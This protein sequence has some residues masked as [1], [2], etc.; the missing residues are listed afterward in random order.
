MNIEYD[1]VRERIAELIRSHINSTNF[2][3]ELADKILSDPDILIKDQS[4]VR[5]ATLKEV[6]EWLDRKIWY[7][8][9]KRPDYT[10]ITRTENEA[11]KSGKFPK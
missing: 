3:S 1:R 11:L 8:R 6:G 9:S 10:V 4:K 2:A 5:E 7:T